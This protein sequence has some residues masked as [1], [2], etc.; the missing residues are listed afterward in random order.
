MSV[1]T[2]EGDPGK[3]RYFKDPSWCV[4]PMESLKDAQIDP[5]V[6]LGCLFPHAKVKY[7]HKDGPGCRIWIAEHLNPG[8]EAHMDPWDDP[9]S[10]EYDGPCVVCNCDPC[11]CDPHHDN[12]ATA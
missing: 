5:R 1:G 12:E 2:S 6:C 4:T 8:K 9:D 11:Q 10:P 3:L 7:E